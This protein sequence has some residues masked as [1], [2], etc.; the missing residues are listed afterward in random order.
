MFQSFF[1]DSFFLGHKTVFVVRVYEQSIMHAYCKEAACVY[2][3]FRVMMPIC[4]EKLGPLVIVEEQYRLT[5]AW[6]EIERLRVRYLAVTEGTGH[7]SI[8]ILSGI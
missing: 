4:S 2:G 1:D 3:Q 6:T 7:V 8:G 5:A